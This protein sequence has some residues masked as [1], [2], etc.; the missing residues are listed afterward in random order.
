MLNDFLEEYKKE[1]YEFRFSWDPSERIMDAEIEKDV[2]KNQYHCVRRTLPYECLTNE[3]LLISELR[4]II[5][6]IEE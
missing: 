2:G 1:G 6:K 4:K 3:E 5:E